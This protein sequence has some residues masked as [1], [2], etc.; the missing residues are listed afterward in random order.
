MAHEPARKRN[1]TTEADRQPGIIRLAVGVAVFMG[2]AV[3]GASL[4]RVEFR[5]TTS[6]E[7][8]VS[9]EKQEGLRLFLRSRGGA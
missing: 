2:L 8:V 5:K 7:W 3:A 4:L 1:T 9:K 6:S